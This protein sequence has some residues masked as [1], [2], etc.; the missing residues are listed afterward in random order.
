MQQ[1]KTKYITDLFQRENQLQ[2]NFLAL[3]ISLT[4]LT[5][6]VIA[7]KRFG[8]VG[9]PLF[10]VVRNIWKDG[11]PHC[12]AT[13]VMRDVFASFGLCHIH[14]AWH[15]I[16]FILYMFARHFGL[17]KF[18]VFELKFYPQTLAVQQEQEP[19]KK[20]LR[21]WEVP[22]PLYIFFCSIMPKNG[23]FCPKTPVF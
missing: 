20:E 6:K 21:T 5:V 2:Q 9:R 11:C 15:Q 10:P 7:T 1:N 18:D 12:R 14:S 22:S 23:V 16:S 19:A 8:P 13:T 3:N 4:N 17:Q